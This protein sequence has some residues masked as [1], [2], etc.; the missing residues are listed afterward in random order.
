[1]DGSGKL[2]IPTPWAKFPSPNLVDRS[3]PLWV[4][5][6]KNRC[7][8]NLIYFKCVSWYFIESSI[9][10]ARRSTRFGLGKFAHG[11]GIQSGPERSILHYFQTKKKNTLVSGNGG[12][13]KNLHPSGCKFIFSNQFN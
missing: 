8:K 10:W 12:D 11:A 5:F 7:Y 13:E 6:S 2:F 1:M 4:R 9:R 3:G